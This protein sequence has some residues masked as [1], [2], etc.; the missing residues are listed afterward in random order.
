M[1]LHVN[2]ALPIDGHCLLLARPPL[3]GLQERLRGRRLWGDD[4]LKEADKGLDWVMPAI[5]AL[6]I[7][8]R[9]AAWGSCCRWSDQACRSSH[10]AMLVKED[11]GPTRPLLT[12]A[13]DGLQTSFPRCWRFAQQFVNHFFACFTGSCRGC[14]VGEVA[15]SIR[16]ATVLHRICSFGLDLITCLLAHEVFGVNSHALLVIGWVFIGCRSHPRHG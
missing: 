15:F 13:S 9:P 10:R 7:A 16:Q 3:V 2:C 11:R 6:I 14:K 5:Q 12:S 4:Q 1:K 8:T